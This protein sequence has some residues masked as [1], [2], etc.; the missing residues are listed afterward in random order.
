M[1]RNFSRL[2]TASSVKFLNKC[3]F[4]SDREKNLCKKEITQAFIKHHQKILFTKA[5]KGNVTVALDGDDYVLRIEIMLSDE[6]TYIKSEIK[7][8]AKKIENKLNDCLKACY[9][10]NYISSR[11]CYSLLSNDKSLFRAYGLPK[12]YKPGNPYRIIVSCVNTTL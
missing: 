12:I 10:T 11:D 5:D 8:S 9:N 6:N 2:Q 7:N 1:S 4:L 3:S